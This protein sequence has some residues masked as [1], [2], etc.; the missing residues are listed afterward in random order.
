M[1]T[2]CSGWWRVW[3]DIFVCL[4]A[5]TVVLDSIFSKLGGANQTFRKL[6]MY[7]KLICACCHQIWRGLA[8]FQ[9]AEKQW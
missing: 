4:Y 1:L 7:S 5:S 2:V 8:I 3:F 6:C 9:F